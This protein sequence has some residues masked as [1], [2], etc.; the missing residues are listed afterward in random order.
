[1]RY[2]NWKMR[3]VHS[4]LVINRFLL[5][6]LTLLIPK[7]A[8]YDTPAELFFFTMAIHLSILSNFSPPMLCI[9]FN[10]FCGI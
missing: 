1:M 7:T 8:P 5:N 2:K 4:V 6:V 9:D 10:N 3:Q